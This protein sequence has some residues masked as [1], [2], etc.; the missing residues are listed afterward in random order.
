VRDGASGDE[1][2]G[3]SAGAAD[4]GDLTRRAEQSRR[5]LRE[6]KAARNA[7]KSESEKRKAERT[8]SDGMPLQTGDMVRVADT[9]Q[10]G[11]VVSPPDG[12]GKTTVL[13]GT[14][15]M[16]LPE[17]ALEKIDGSQREQRG[18][19]E[20]RYAKIIRAKM[21]NVH[22]SINLHGMNLDEAE[23]AVDK[24]LDDAVLAHMNE[25]VLNHGRGSG[26]LRDG[27][28]AMLKGHRHVVKFRN[29]EFDEGGDGVTV[30]TLSDR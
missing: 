15:R 9:G 7:K 21:G 28:R 8:I 11:E 17:A 27:L 5:K 12:K 4:A 22:A 29:G 16:T 3:L 1:S 25:V 6:A 26:V 10:T 30:V 14:I 24:Y 19:S 13:I 18:Q 20:R 23:R 2:G